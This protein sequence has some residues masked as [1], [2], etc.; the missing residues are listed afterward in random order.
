MEMVARGRV[1]GF[2][3]SHPH[4]AGKL[5]FVRCLMAGILRELVG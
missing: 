1:L 4:V 2:Y 3:N 5:Y